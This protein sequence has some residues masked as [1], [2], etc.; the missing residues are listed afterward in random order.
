[1]ILVVDVIRDS[2]GIVIGTCNI[3]GADAGC[4]YCRRG[5]GVVGIG[6]DIFNVIGAD[7][8]CAYRRR[9][10]G[11]FGIGIGIGIQ[12][13]AREGTSSITPPLMIRYVQTPTR[14]T[15]SDVNDCAIGSTDSDVRDGD[16]AGG[17]GRGGLRTPLTLIRIHMNKMGTHRALGKERAKVK[18]L[19]KTLPIRVSEGIPGFSHSDLL[20]LR[21]SAAVPL[22]ALA[23]AALVA[24]AVVHTAALARQ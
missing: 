10:S 13:G 21:E 23:L 5:G 22:P 20:A 2:T 15:A 16:G 12:V 9:G 7:E 6:I 4:A 14:A 3:S 17:S 24:R 19:L 8:G 1:M 11:V 18:T